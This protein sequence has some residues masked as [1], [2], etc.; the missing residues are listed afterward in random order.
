MC[1]ETTGLLL[2]TRAHQYLADHETCERRR[3]GR[4]HSS[5]ENRPGFCRPPGVHRHVAESAEPGTVRLTAPNPGS[6]PSRCAPTRL[7]QVA[8]CPKEAR[9][10]VRNVAD[11]L[12]P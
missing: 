8:E 12:D 4:R 1:W 2:A 5:G 11:R 10:A 6:L 7:S 9:R 3:S